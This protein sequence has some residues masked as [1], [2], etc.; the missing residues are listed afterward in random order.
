M[1]VGYELGVEGIFFRLPHIV[2]CRESLPCDQIFASAIV[3][4]SFQD[5]FHQVDISVCDRVR[6]C[7]KVRGRLLCD[8]DAGWCALRIFSCQDGS[9]FEAVSR[10]VCG[11]FD[12]AIV[13]VKVG[14]H[15]V[16]VDGGA[17][18]VVTGSPHEKVNRGQFLHESVG[19]WPVVQQLPAF[20][21]LRSE[22]PDLLTKFEFGSLCCLVI[23]ELYLLLCELDVS[24]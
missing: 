2:L 13:W 17:D 24:P 3:L 11:S 5:F 21:C 10:E 4:A 12:W 14:L 23:L 20:L 7:L 18:M 1:K 19:S 6:G 8:F 22:N 16:D 15:A 9:G